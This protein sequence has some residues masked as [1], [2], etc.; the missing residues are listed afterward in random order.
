MPVAERPV[1]H[2]RLGRIDHPCRPIGAALQVACYR[3]HPRS[4]VRGWQFRIH[5]EL[6]R[7]AEGMRCNR[8][9]AAGSGRPDAIEDRVDEVRKVLCDGAVCVLPAEH[10]FADRGAANV[11]PSDILIVPVAGERD[12][13]LRVGRTGRDRLFPPENA[14]VVIDLAHQAEFLN[15]PHQPLRRQLVRVVRVEVG[16][17]PGIRPRLRRIRHIAFDRAFQKVKVEVPTG[18]PGVL[19]ARERD[20][21]AVLPR[22]HSSKQRPPQLPR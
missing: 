5:V 20:Y 6:E 11:Q 9:D 7:A 10:S 16:R 2:G 1:E 15:V 3:G 4:G 22:G 17:H 12:R 21:H 14:A 19:R 13:A 18:T 8:E